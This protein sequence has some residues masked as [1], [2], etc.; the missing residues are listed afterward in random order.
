MRIAGARKD[1][2]FRGFSYGTRRAAETHG[3]GPERIHASM[4]TTLLIGLNQQ[5]A[6]NSSMENIANNLANI[7]TPGYKRDTSIFEEYVSQARSEEGQTG[8][9][10][11]I[12]YVYNAGTARD[13]S[14]G[15]IDYTGA[16]YDF[17][18]N[19]HG[20]FVVQTANGP[21]YTRDGHFTLNSEGTLVTED[22]DAVQGDGGNITV[23]QDDGNAFFAAD[24][25]IT[26]IKGQLGKLQMVQFDNENQLSKEG[27]TLYTA[28]AG[29][30]PQ[31][32]KDAKLKQGA[33]ES[34]NV[35]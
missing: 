19:G 34:S 31:P 5:M 14:Q 22:G 1:Q 26:G 29:Q 32:S 21:R 9:A 17:A 35:E 27:G 11:T 33:L 13:F 30:T 2:E 7:S 15:R 20:Y 10:H 28:P 18:M 4:D 12:S 23:T 25:T 3:D 24:G 8:G 6:T 16:P